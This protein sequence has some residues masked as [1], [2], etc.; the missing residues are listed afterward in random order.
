MKT[1]RLVGIIVLAVIVLPLLWYKWSIRPVDSAAIRI[2]VEIPSGS[3]LKKIASILE[4]KEV[5]RSS[6]A[7]LLYSKIHGR[8]GKSQ[9][10]TY[11]LTTDMNAWEVLDALE[12]GQMGETIITIPE[13]FTVKDIDVLLAKKGL[14]QAG[15]IEQCARSCDFSQFTFLPKGVTLADRGGKI[16]GYL[17]PDTYF[18]L[19][20]GFTAKSFL[21]RL[22]S[23]FQKKVVEGMSSDLQHSS[24]SLHEIITMASLIEEETRTEEERPVVSGILWKRFEANSGLG[25]DAA[26]RYILNKPTAAITKS[27]LEVDSP[28]NLRRY[29]GLP[30][31]PIASPGISSIEAAL[32]PEAS[33]YLYY[34]HGKDGKIHYA[35]TN[36][37]HNE[38]R[39]KYL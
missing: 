31:G 25:V 23:T 36:E 24:R 5:I 15:D 35:E 12:G 11:V 19:S 33:P 2:P 29:R 14:T 6:K 34:L 16:E 8:G 18:V 22:L 39:A 38:N 9:A 32:N 1:P 3:S 10:G 13:G 26:V 37:E 17:Y 4:E 21:D 27:D 7:F 30:P 20:E 28:Y